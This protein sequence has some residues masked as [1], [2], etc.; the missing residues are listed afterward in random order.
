MSRMIKKSDKSQTGLASIIIV[1][2]LTI[3]ISLLTLGF[4]RLMDRAIQQAS[5]ND[6]NAAADYAVRVGITEV[7]SY[8]KAYPGNGSDHCDDLTKPGKP[9]SRVGGISGD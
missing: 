2:M 8:L 5:G 7:A 1:F 4:S 9:L 3:I 6:L